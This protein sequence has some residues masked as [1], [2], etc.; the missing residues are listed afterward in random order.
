MAA[1]P[2]T[3]PLSAPSA[4]HVQDS[5]PPAVRGQS[6]PPQASA[7]VPPPSLSAA[8]V[9]LMASPFAYVATQGDASSEVDD[10]VGGDSP[11]ASNVTTAVMP[12]APARDES[13]NTEQ[14]AAVSMEP[15]VASTPPAQVRASSVARPDQD[16][17]IVD[18]PLS[19]RRPGSVPSP[20]EAA[21]IP[22]RQLVMSSAASGVGGP[23]KA[24]H[25][26]P[27]SLPNASEDS[28]LNPSSTPQLA[29]D[30][31]LATGSLG[32]PLQGNHT[33]GEG[34]LA[35]NSTGADAD[36]VTNLARIRLSGA[37]SGVGGE[38]L[39]TASST[40]VS[41]TSAAST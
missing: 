21:Q 40:P 25:A 3:P 9:R 34:S 27:A 28:Q 39:E 11:A 15:P 33:A 17:A 2:A 22:P 24:Q 19:L 29:R 6:V 41:F 18:A 31:V 32:H 12:P 38:R 8:A 35:V 30:M 37:C 14:R 36:V 10:M 13:P 1:S 5:A 26:A 23:S 20:E 4:N 16:Y 7:E